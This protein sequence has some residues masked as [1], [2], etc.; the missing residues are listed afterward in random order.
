M[1]IKIRAPDDNVVHIHLRAFEQ[2][3]AKTVVHC[4]T[5]STRSPCKSERCN[6]ELVSAKVCC[7]RG[8]LLVTVFDWDVPIARRNVNC[9]EYASLAKTKGIE[10]VINPR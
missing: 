6:I 1:G 4:P 3:L 2:E 10:G 7:E 9:T 5:E 8:F